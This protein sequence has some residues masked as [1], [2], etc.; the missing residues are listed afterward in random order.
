MQKAVMVLCLTMGL[1]LVSLGA[2]AQ[3]GP[4]QAWIPGLASLVLPGLGQLLNDQMDK[5]LVHFGVDVG[6]LVIGYYA[7]TLLPLGFPGFVVLP[8]AH[9]AWAVYSGY[10]AYTVAKEQGFTVGLIENGVSLSY[11]F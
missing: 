3:N 1:L 8:L 6:I 11:R 5:A 10:D 4:S 7:T 9:L 2:S